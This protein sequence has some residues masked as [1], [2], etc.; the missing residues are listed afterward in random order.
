MKKY[1]LKNKEEKLTD[2][3]SIRVNLHMAENIKRVAKVRKLTVSE[4]I[5]K[6]LEESF[7]AKV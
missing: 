5:R 3:I 1:N 6:L 4:V 7:S 2:F